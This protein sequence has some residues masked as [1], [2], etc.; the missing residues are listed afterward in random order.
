MDKIKKYRTVIQ[1][2]LSEYASYKSPYGDVENQTIFDRE[3]DHYQI[4]HLGW[5]NNKRVYGCSIH[6]DIKNDKVWI[7]HN[8]T[9]IDIAQ[10]L[11]E[12][13]IPREDIVLGFQSPLLRQYTEYAVS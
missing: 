6:L 5:E 13:G 2:I 1:K 9:D 10:E 12:L 7:Q 4:V 11:V 8:T 3:H